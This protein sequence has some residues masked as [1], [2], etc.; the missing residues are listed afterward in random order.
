MFQRTF[1]FAALT[2]TALLAS[3]A[4]TTA[5]AGAA[6]TCEYSGPSETVTV[7]MSAEN[8]SAILKVVSGEI[9]VNASSGP[10]TCTNGTPTLANTEFINVLDNSGSGS[11]TVSILEPAVFAATGG[12]SFILSPSGGIHDRL[13]VL[14]AAGN[15]KIV[16]GANGVDS[17]GNATKDISFLGSFDEFLLDGG[18]AGEDTLSAHGSA[19]TGAAISAGLVTLSGSTG[20]DTLEGGETG[21]LLRGGNN[22]DQLHGFGGNDYLSGDDLTA[23]DDAIDGGAGTDMVAFPFAEVPIT[24]DLA[25]AGPQATGQGSDTIAEVENVEGAGSGDT[26][27]GNASANELRGLSGNDT[28]EGRGGADVLEGSIGTDTL[29]YAEAPTGVTVDLGANAAGGGDG[30]DTISGF[31]NLTGSNLADTLTGS[32]VQNIISALG[33]NDHVD[34]RDGGPDKVSCGT[35]TDTAVAD[36]LTVDAIQPDCEQVEAIVDAKPPSGGGGSVGQADTTLVFRM[37]GARRQR[38]LVKPLRV[39]LRCPLEACTVTLRAPGTGTKKKIVRRLTDGA[40]KTV[41]IPLTRGRREAIEEL[42]DRGGRPK[43]KVGATAT[44]AAG[45]VVRSSLSVTVRR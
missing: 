36:R 15:D 10:V 6:T 12:A 22:D 4:L 17:D 24:V 14:G 39:K 33:G 19:A 35:G 29:G 27:R 37:G 40:P 31:E 21:D 9:K 26:L 11:T 7:A 42:L 20:D 38:L 18:I 8:D 45:N 2:A 5:S 44:D 1:R 43:A 13:Q 23:G 3:A 32:A 41:R 25:K 34:V 28:I 16:V 30:E